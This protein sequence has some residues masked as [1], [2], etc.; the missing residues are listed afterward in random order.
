MHHANNVD[1]LTSS[2]F[3]SIVLCRG[4]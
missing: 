1:P 2:W 4:W 3:P